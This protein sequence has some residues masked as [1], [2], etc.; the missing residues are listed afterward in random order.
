MDC[1]GA[2]K[3]ISAQVANGG[4]ILGAEEGR[5]TSTV[6]TSNRGGKGRSQDLIRSCLYFGHTKRP[7]LRLR[8]MTER[9][10][11]KDARLGGKKAGSAS[12]LKAID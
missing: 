12:A 3:G 10:R 7:T 2:G 11:N 1:M 9:S 4:V 8:R 6:S 5:K